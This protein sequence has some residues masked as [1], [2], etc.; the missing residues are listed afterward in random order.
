MK[1]KDLIKQLSNISEEINIEERLI[2]LNG[3]LYIIYVMNW[4]EI[5][6]NKSKEYK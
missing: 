1:P 6:L 2:S 5:Q 4:M 3:Q